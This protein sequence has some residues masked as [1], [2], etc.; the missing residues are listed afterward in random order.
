M[1]K[2]YCGIIALLLLG[3]SLRAQTGGA[4][5]PTWIDLG[6]GRGYYDWIYVLTGVRATSNIDLYVATYDKVASQG[7]SYKIAAAQAAAL[8]VRNDAEQRVRNALDRFKQH[9]PEFFEQVMQEQRL[10][11]P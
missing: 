11:L 1:R 7:A 8:A 2:A 5:G 3:G 6:R 4:D 9:D 10:T